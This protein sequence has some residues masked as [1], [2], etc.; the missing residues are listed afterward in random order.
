MS[1][2]KSKR[3]VSQEEFFDVAITLRGKITEMLKEDFG[4]DKEYIR[5]EDGRIIKNKDYWL[6]QEVR[7]RIFDYA[8]NLIMNITEA[9]TIYITTQAEY[10]VRRRY[11][12]NAI[13]NCEQIKQELN[14]AAKVLP[15]PKKKYLQ[16]ND[17][18]K[19]EKN[20]L[21]SWRKSDNKVLKKLMEA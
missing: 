17:M 19:Q 7:R 5:T 21:K 18:F 6:Y 2:P 15:I 12:T 9:N 14:Y 1:I 4:D 3:P 16:Y 20:H 8:A 10:A 13:A 11:M